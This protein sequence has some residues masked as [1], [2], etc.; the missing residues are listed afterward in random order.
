[1]DIGGSIDSHFDSHLQL[2]SSFYHFASGILLYIQE[3]FI[4]M[5]EIKC[6]QFCVDSARIVETTSKKEI[7]ININPCSLDNVE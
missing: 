1:M 4:W 6:S 2:F 5:L 3:W 7:P